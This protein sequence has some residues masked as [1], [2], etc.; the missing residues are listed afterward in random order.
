MA[1][2]TEPETASITT[3]AAD[4][5]VVEMLRSNLEALVEEML[6][7]LVRS[8]Y[9]TLMRESRDCSFLV[10]DEHGRV[11]ATSSSNFTHATAYR[12]LVQ[13]AL[14]KWGRDGLHEGDVIVANH[15]YQA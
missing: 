10:V 1:T 15:P 12:R 4:V 13:A 8:A 14:A 2:T 9:S 7:L 11:M 3:P 5:V 6:H